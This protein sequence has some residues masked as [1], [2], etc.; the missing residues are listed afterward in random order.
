V[1]TQYG[2][3]FNQRVEGKLTLRDSPWDPI[4]QLLPVASDVSARLW[5]PSSFDRDI[6]LAG[7]LDG[8]AFAPF[9]DTIGG[10]RWPGENGGP[11]R[12]SAES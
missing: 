5:T 3:A 2:T 4:A 11:K 10:S 12:G 9:I 6:A 1:H 7:K 8:D